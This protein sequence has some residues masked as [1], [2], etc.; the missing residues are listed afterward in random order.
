MKLSHRLLIALLPD[1]EIH[2]AGET[3][4]VKLSKVI[5]IGMER[6]ARVIRRRKR[7]EAKALMAKR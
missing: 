5:N 2:A 7:G 1:V 3:R 4:K 6:V